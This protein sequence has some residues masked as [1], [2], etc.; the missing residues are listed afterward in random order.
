MIITKKAISRRTMLR[1]AG[2]AIALPLLDAMIPAHTALAATAGAPVRR[3]GYVYI[4]MGSNTAEWTPQGE[5]RVQEL[6]PILR[7]DR[8]STRL[9][10]SHT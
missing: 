6:S 4:P 1:G 8:K 7:P 3:L 2:A 5:G 9:N 10:S